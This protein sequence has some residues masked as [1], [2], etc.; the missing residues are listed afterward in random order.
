[1]NK[2]IT[3]YIP[4]EFRPN[5]RFCHTPLQVNFVDLG[6]SPLCESYISV[7]QLN[8]MEP[9]YPL[10]SYVC[11]ECFLVQLD[12]YVSPGEIFTEYAYFSSYSDSWVQHAKDYTEQVIERFGLGVDN[13]VM[14]I[15]SN[16]GY[17]LQHFAAHNI[18][19][20][21][22]EPAANIAEVAEKKGI[23]TIVKFF[24]ENVAKE[25]VKEYGQADLLI[26]NNVLA[27]V[28]DI[29]DFLAGIGTVRGIALGGTMS[30]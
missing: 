12:E 30:G 6:M 10:H 14:E 22:I 20:M 11:E 5:C 17:L 13:K 29:N 16:D 21:G 19:V 9:F 7:D 3:N 26:G 28:P 2:G 4:S 23:P 15:A 18:P 8:K 1:M 27:H 24:G 25:I